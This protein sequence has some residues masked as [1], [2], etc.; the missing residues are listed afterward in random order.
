MDYRAKSAN[1]TPSRLRGT[2]AWFATIAC[3]ACSGG[4]RTVV[5]PPP[6]TTAVLTLTIQPDPE[7]VQVAQLLGW[8]N[9]IPGADVKVTPADS[10]LGTTQSFTSN[11]VGVVSIPDAKA[12]VYVVEVQ[13]LFT[14]AE[15][16]KLGQSPSA[17]GF[18]GRATI[19]SSGGTFAFSVAV[20]A[21]KR[22]S[23]IFNE[24]SWRAGSPGLG[25][26]CFNDNGFLEV[27]NNSDTTIYLDGITVGESYNLFYEYPAIP[28]SVSYPFL[29]DPL[30][31]WALWH[32]MFPGN[33]RDNPLKPGGLVTIAQDAIDHRELYPTA[34]GL[35]DLRGADFEF[36]GP[37]DVDNPTVPNMIDRSYDS[38]QGDGLPS[39]YSGG[40]FFLA[41]PLSLDSLPRMTDPRSGNTRRWWRF[42]ASSILDFF[43]TYVQGPDPSGLKFCSPLAAP[44]FDREPG[45]FFGYD[46]LTEFRFSESRK[47]I[48]TTADGRAILQHTRSSAA[49][50][51]KGLIS[52]GK[53]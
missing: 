27:Y 53:M 8:A 4:E 45:A 37:V 38:I 48:G 6:P 21:S 47:R 15:A 50:F 30:G 22:R 40:T 41:L 1:V 43:I 2:T 51:T 44:N 20:P 29:T 10:N 25:E 31:V 34:Q 16:A 17:T 52:P 35:P 24:I 12:G 42:P 33:G 23:L 9:G 28:C 19:N 49:D 7:D 13:R 39:I 26:C 11:V 46:D 36:I 14:S 5:E 18:V 3:F 32:Y